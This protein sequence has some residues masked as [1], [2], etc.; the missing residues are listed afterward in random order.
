MNIS[1]II[2]EVNETGSHFF[3]PE[4]LRFFG[5]TPSD[6]SVEAIEDGNY[7]IEAPMFAGWER[8]EQGEQAGWTRRVYNPTTKK[9]LNVR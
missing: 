6:F 3:E 9:L 4:T 1:E 2:D 5:Q 8:R 7:L